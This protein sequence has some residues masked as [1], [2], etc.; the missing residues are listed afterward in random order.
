VSSETVAWFAVQVV[1]QHEKK[2][3]TLLHIKGLECFLPSISVRKHWSDRTKI[4]PRPLIPGYV[5]CRTTRSCFASVLR[6]PGV[7]RIVS[8]GGSAF[9]V[10]DTEID[11][12]VRIVN[13]GLQVHPVSYLTLGQ[14][15]QVKDGP[16]SGI[17]GVVSQL[18]NRTR[19]IVSIEMIMKSISV[20]VGSWE[21]S[22][23]D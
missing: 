12:L 11:S 2:V 3:E 22:V 21:V 1:P 15:V 16:L 10:S 23:V 19:V 7:Y 17:M 6:T 20:D 18:K 8:F 4:A 13:S 14:K 5:F 9:P